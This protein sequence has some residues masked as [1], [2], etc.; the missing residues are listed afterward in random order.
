LRLVERRGNHYGLGPLGAAM[1]GNAGLAAMVEHHALLY[2]DLRDP[3]ALLQRGAA[4]D[5]ALSQYWRYAGRTDARALNVCETSPYTALMGAS[6]SL[7][8][9]EVIDAYPLQR[10]TCLLDAGGGDG[11]FVAAV[12]ARA[13]HLKFVVFDLPA[14]VEQARSRFAAAGLSGRA[15]VVGGNF[16]SDPLPQSADIASLV[17]VLHDHNDDAA[18]HILRAIHKALA[19]GGSLLIAEP[20]SQTPG[21]EPVGDAY[22]GFYLMAMGS[23]RPRTKQEIERLLLAAGY[24]DIRLLRSNV[25]L[26]TSVIVSQ[27]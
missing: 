11:S 8:A 27:A 14:V 16:L 23:G 20:M 24:Q 13:P 6:L 5:T 9:A 15:T 7:V 17:R 4:G 1:V 2:A 3:V 10:H 18:L 19:R 25:P 26:L 22:F 12:A 21:A